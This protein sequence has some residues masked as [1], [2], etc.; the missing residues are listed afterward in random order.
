MNLLIFAA[1]VSSV[2]TFDTSKLTIP[3][4][5]FTLESN[6]L[7]VVLAKDPRLP[8]VAVNI[9][10]HVGPINES[11]GRTGF[12]HLFEHLMFQGS[13][14]VGDDLHF[15]LLESRGASLVNGTTGNDRTN[16]FETVPSNELELALWLES[17]RMGYLLGS[18]TQEKLDNQRK[19]VQN[20]RRQSVEN[21]PYGPSEERM[22]ELLYPPG[23]PYH[24]NVI[25]SMDDLNAATLDD[26]KN[27]YNAYYAPANATLVIAGDFDDQQAR[28]LVAKYFGTLSKRVVAD[29]SAQ[30]T[31]KPVLPLREEVHEPVALPKVSMAWLT[32]SAFAPGDA[33]CDVLAFILGGGKSSRLYR[34]LVYNLQIAQAAHASQASSQLSSM[35][36]IDVIARPGSNME[37]IEKEV[38]SVIAT[39]ANEGPTEIELEQAKN[40]LVTHTVSSLQRIGGFGGVAD[41]L[42]RYNHYLGT[43]EFLQKDIERYITLTQNDIKQA[44]GKYLSPTDTAVVVTVPE[45]AQ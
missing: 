39:L 23:H 41:T 28:A 8:I 44:A 20:E 27:F 14:H 36:G 18:L 12:A 7:Q 16:Y 11:K 33:A 19:V 30:M 25:G 15:K 6:G 45:V 4:T 35:F 10:Y 1:L 29:K 43:T 13:E 5:T 42:N 3:H 26:V 22:V 32:P 9:W 17:D 2:G 34:R 38:G 31:P 40:A 37:T 24:G 21:Q